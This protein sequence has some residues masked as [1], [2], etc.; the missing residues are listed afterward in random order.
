[1][2]GQIKLCFFWQIATEFFKFNWSYEIFCCEWRSDVKLTQSLYFGVGRQVDDIIC[3][4]QSLVIEQFAP[5]WK[6]KKN[7]E[8]NVKI[9]ST[10]FAHVKCYL[11]MVS[12]LFNSSDLLFTNFWRLAD[13]IW[14][15]VSLKWFDTFQEYIS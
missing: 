15:I 4:R 7:F 3:C 5:R 11:C 6:L 2:Q 14:T 8:E 10:F 12:F 1:M 9:W 13:Y